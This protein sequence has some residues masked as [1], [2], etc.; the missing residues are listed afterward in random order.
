VALIR[1]DQEAAEVIEG[2]GECPGLERQQ[3]LVPARAA[4]EELQEPAAVLLGRRE[5]TG[6]QGVRAREAAVD[7]AVRAWRVPPLVDVDE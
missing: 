2:D 3:R 4:L 5:I 1:L 7:V 6:E